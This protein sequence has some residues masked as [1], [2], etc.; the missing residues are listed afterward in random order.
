MIVS[1]Q[2]KGALAK[3]VI[4]YG[5]QFKILELSEWRHSVFRRSFRE[6]LLIGYEK[7]PSGFDDF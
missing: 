3:G 4:G 6:K 5:T 7:L 1:S 2:E